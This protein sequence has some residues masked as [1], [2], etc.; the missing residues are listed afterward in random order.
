MPDLEALHRGKILLKTGMQGSKSSSHIQRVGAGEIVPLATQDPVADAFRFCWMANLSDTINSIQLD[1]TESAGP[2]RSDSASEASEVEVQA[3]RFQFG[4]VYQWSC[5]Y[6]IE[7]TT[8]RSFRSLRGRMHR[9]GSGNYAAGAVQ[10]V[11]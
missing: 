7:M 9:C 11:R 3:K 5:S 2:V 10:Q 4:C 1:E 8:P 6:H